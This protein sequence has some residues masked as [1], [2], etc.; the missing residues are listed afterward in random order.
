M[1]ATV[2]QRRAAMIVSVGLLLSACGTQPVIV[3]G[4][5]VSVPP[6]RTEPKRDL[7]AESYRAAEV[8]LSKL[9]RDL[10]PSKKVLIASIVD[11][12]DL[13]RTSTFGRI[14]AEQIGSRLSQRDVS[15]DEL[16]LRSDTVLIKE[17]QGEFLLSRNIQKLS[18]DRDIQAVFV[19]TYAVGGADVYIS[20]RL[21]RVV[22]SSLISSYDYSLPITENIKHLLNLQ[23]TAVRV[24]VQ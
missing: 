8:L 15:V 4:P 3:S 19:G 1:F 5:P 12:D 6:P 13:D 7:I 22:D 10:D 20:V 11:I 14:V 9:K 24:S 16:K 2:Q 17:K 23:P 21:V 18:I